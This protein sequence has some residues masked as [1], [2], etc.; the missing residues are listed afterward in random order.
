MDVYIEEIILNPIYRSSQNESEERSP[1]LY[2]RF[3]LNTTF[4]VALVLAGQ[5]YR[6]SITS[7][8]LVFVILGI[9]LELIADSGIHFVYSA[10]F[11]REIP[12]RTAKV[13]KYMFTTY[14]LLW[15]L[16]MTYFLSY[17]YRHNLEEYCLLSMCSQSKSGLWVLWVLMVY[18]YAKLMVKHIRNC[19]ILRRELFTMMIIG[20]QDRNYRNLAG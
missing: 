6:E 3:I 11:N 14:N 5:Y 15:G 10:I 13:K 2:C 19:W 7:P 16:A 17:Y 4:I 1:Y 18:F 9:C 8:I 20:S 12:T